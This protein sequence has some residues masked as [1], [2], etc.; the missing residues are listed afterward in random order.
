[1]P[2]VKANGIDLYYQE[3]GEGAPILCIHGTSSSALVWGPSLEELGKRGRCIGYDRRGC[4]RS[5]RPEPYESTHVTDHADDAAALLDALSATPAVVIGRSYGGETALMLAQ[6][7]PDKVRALALLEPAALTL[8]PEA[9]AWA[10][11]LRQRVVRAA[12]N[13]PASVA[14]V[15]LGIVAGDEVWNS[16]PP[17]LRDMF[18]GNGPAIL[19]ELSGSG[20]D[21]T[22]GELSEIE[23]P[24][25]LVSAQDSPEIFRRVDD[26]LAEA[27]PHPERTLVGGGHLIDPA[28]AAVLEFV[29]RILASSPAA[30]A[31]SARPA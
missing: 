4:F 19:A 3:H 8:D 18:T 5:E 31:S 10:E 24:T 16:C 20:L 17:A 15:F 21:L 13:D 22:V 6:R 27:L 12:A 26:R 14:R 25:L 7:F 30:H 2:R 11:T 1:M 29:D 9:E 23:Q 28:H